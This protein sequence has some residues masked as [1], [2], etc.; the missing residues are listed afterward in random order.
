MWD[1]MSQKLIR[2]I[3]LVEISQPENRGTP[4]NKTQGE[5]PE[6]RPIDIS[7]LK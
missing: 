4:H 6:S 5:I 1:D 2:N 3:F 7:Q